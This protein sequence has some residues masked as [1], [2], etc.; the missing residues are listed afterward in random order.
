MSGFKNE[1]KRLMH[2]G[3]EFH[4]V[5][6]ERQDAN[7]AKALPSM[8]SGWYLMRSGK[9]IPVM[10]ED[11]SATPEAIDKKLKEWLDSHVFA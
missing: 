6:Y 10:Q 8:P 3:H 11:A 1:Q 5:T 7:K 9:R 2:R 4:F